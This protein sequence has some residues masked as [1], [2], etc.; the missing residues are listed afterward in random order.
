MRPATEEEEWEDDEERGSCRRQDAETTCCSAP[1]E[2]KGE[3]RRRA[4]DCGGSRMLRPLQPTAAAQTDEDTEMLATR[5]DFEC[6]Q[7]Q[8]QQLRSL[9]MP[10]LPSSLH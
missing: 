1:M 9:L 7:Q 5:L 10:A 4:V 8:R 2:V 6:Q 3:G